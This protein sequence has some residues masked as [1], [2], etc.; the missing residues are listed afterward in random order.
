MSARATLTLY[1]DILR[2]AQ[3]WPSIKRHSIIDEIRN[4]F[5]KNRTEAKPKRVDKMLSEARDGLASLRQQCGLSDAN[6][7]SYAYDDAL[8]RREDGRSR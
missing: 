5:R 7:I 2:T 3:R 4:E 8:R 6:D 1:K